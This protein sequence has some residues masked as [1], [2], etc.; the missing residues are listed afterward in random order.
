MKKSGKKAIKAST[1]KPKSSCTRV[2]TGLG[3]TA[4]PKG[5]GAA[6]RAGGSKQRVKGV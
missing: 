6:A 5:M 2:A 3:N 1:M 4:A